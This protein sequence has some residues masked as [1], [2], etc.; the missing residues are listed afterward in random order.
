MHSSRDVARSCRFALTLLLLA[1]CA[2][3][4][5]P[6]PD[7]AASN[8]A[9]SADAAATTDTGAQEPDAAGPGSSTMSPVDSVTLVFS[10]GEEPARVR[11]AAGAP[12]DVHEAL[13]LLVRGPTEEEEAD[14]VDSWFSAETAG[15]LRSVDVDAD[16]HAVVDF[17]GL[18]ALIPNASSSAGSRLLLMQLNGT[19]FE[20][21]AIESVEYRLDGSCD[22]F[23]E[24][25]QTG[26][27]TH[28]RTDG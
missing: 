20:F 3:D 14:G 11:R 7:G 6:R 21:P 16:G 28:T 17:E 4:A 13:A 8:D 19:V 12:A 15:A 26:C 25:L 18:D 24:W 9:A 23:G 1:G 27:V 5:D 10:R 22:A 2:A